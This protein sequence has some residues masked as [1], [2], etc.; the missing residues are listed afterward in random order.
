MADEAEVQQTTETKQIYDINAGKYVDM[1]VEKKEEKAPETE[2]ADQG[3]GEEK[4]DEVKDEKKEEGEPE[5]SEEEGE[6]KEEGEPE[7]EFDSVTP[8]DFIKNVFGEKYEIQ[9]QEELEELIDN[10][11][12]VMED[13]EGLK[14]Q[15]AELKDQKP[16][17]SSTEEE[18]AFEFIKKFGVP[19]Q[20]EAFQTYAKLIAMDVDNADQRMLLEERFVHENPEL[21]REEAQKKFAR[22]YNRKYS[23]SRENFDGTDAEYKEE[24]EMLEIDKKSEVNK[25]KK[26]LKEQQE[27]FKPTVKDD[28][29]KVPESV[30]KSIEKNAVAYEEFAK[31]NQELVFE[32]NGE[33]VNFKLDKD[34]NA[35]ISKAMLAWVKNPANYDEK[36]TL[37]GVKSPQDMQ[38]QVA[39]ALYLDDIIKTVVSQ[40]KNS[41]TG[42]RIDE[43]GE[44]KPDK[45]KS[46]SG[47]KFKKEPDLYDSALDLLKKKQR[48]NA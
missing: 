37:T 48:Q 1:P 28:A 10:A 31:G 4:V 23:L 44:K 11:T 13:Y 39:A 29:P 25:A 42:K 46:V 9:S 8:D 30:Q 18:K 45:G 24:L 34:K 22:D 33:K 16:K 40:V 2:E 15:L 38:R 35:T 21:T 14:K 43:V 47:A 32:E 5:E 20:G 3:E 12:G 41:V 19:R 7:E 17:F 27:K 36:G 26:F 6:E